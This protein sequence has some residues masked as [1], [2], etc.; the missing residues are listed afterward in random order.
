MNV[1]RRQESERRVAPIEPGQR[2]RVRPGGRHEQPGE[3]EGAVAGWSGGDFA[4][5]LERQQEESRQ[6]EGRAGTPE[7]P[8]VE[9]R[10][11][12]ALPEDRVEIHGLAPL[13]DEAAAED[14]DRPRPPDAAGHRLDLRA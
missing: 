4:A 12:L 2:P 1:I 8:E 10:E 7:D 14:K 6:E 3:Q 13:P 9:E 5:E 11:P